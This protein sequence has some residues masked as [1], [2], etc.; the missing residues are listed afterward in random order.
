L[1]FHSPAEDIKILKTWGSPLQGMTPE[2]PD[3]TPETGLYILDTV[4]IFSALIGEKK[5][6]ALERTCLLLQL[7]QD[8]LDKFHNAGNDAHFT[9]MALRDMAQGPPLDMQREQR[10]PNQ[11]HGTKQVTLPDEEEEEEEFAVSD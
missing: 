3:S 2:V 1:V 9:M 5:P 4:D 8:S 11:S 10:W 7:P 6:R